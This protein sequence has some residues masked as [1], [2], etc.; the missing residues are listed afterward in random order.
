[1]QIV[2]MESL[3]ISEEK[4]QLLKEPFEAQGHTF[5]EY[6][7]SSDESVLISRAKDADV[8][9]LANMPLPLRVLDACEHLRYTRL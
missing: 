6:A 2:I 1:M 7:K 5:T 9:L 4:L 8:I 3:G